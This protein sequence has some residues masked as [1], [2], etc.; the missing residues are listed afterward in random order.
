VRSPGGLIAEFPTPQALLAGA[1]ALHALGYRELDSYTPF[2]VPGMEERLGRRPSRLPRFAFAGGLVGAVLG[3]G[4]QW[5]AD[6][7]TYPLRI[8]GRPAHAAPAFIPATFEACVL[9]AALVAV[10]GLLVALRLPELRHPVFETPGFERASADRFWLA[11]GSK[12]PLFDPQ[13]TRAALAELDPLRVTSI[14][15]VST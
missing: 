3:Y 12:D 10:V 2:P 9:G 6:V 7:W 13:R 4:I 1:S 15:D 8:G 14:P 11:V 5:Y